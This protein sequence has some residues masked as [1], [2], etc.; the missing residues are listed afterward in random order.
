MNSVPKVNGILKENRR[1][2]YIANKCLK[3]KKSLIN[4]C[5]K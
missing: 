3:K 1:E 4:Y 5:L 2:Y